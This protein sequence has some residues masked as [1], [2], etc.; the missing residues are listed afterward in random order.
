MALRQ[1]ACAALLTVGLAACTTQ[2]IYVKEQDPQ[3]FATWNVDPS[4]HRLGMNDRIKV[5]FPLTPEN[6]EE[7]LVGPDGYIGLKIAGRIKAQGLSV[8]ELQDKI[9]AAASRNLRDPIIVASLSDSRSARVVVGGQVKNPGVYTLTARPTVLEA[10][11]LAGGML[12]EGRMS[13][14]VLLRPRSDNTAMLRKVDLQRFVATGDAR[15]NPKLQPE[16]MVFVP[17]SR[18]AEVNWWIEQY[19]NRNL[20]F[21]REITYNKNQAVP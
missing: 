11:M 3:G 10:V 1:L 17:R 13:E 8:S 9:A 6:N 7:V 4:P 16:D 18:V 14:V 21:G 20:P 2:D 5:D 19:I 15:E 12:G